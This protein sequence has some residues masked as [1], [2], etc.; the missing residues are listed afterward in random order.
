MRVLF[1]DFRFIPRFSGFEVYRK[2]QTAKI[3]EHE[4]G[5]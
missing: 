5:P 2:K 1:H 3:G 4:M